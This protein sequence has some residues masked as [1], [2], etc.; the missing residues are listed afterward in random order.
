VSDKK[1]YFLGWAFKKIMIR[2]ERQAGYLCFDDLINE[3]AQ[4]VVYDL[5]Y[6]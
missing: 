3:H 4:I 5:K 2:R 1:N 6:P